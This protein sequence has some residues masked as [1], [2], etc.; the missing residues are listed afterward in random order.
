[1]SNPFS[2]Q[3]LREDGP[4]AIETSCFAKGDDLG[5]NFRRVNYVAAYADNDKPSH[6][7]WMVPGTFEVSR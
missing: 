2:R 7:V 5:F 4:F 6:C 3:P 1:M